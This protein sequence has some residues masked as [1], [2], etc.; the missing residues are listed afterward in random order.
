MTPSDKC[1]GPDAGHLRKT[2]AQLDLALRLFLS[3]GYSESA[4]CN[5]RRGQWHLYQRAV[6]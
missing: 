2:L 1:L 4:F 6:Q 3:T 5:L